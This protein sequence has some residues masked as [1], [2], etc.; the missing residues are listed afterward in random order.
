MWDEIRED[1]VDSFRQDPRVADRWS[2]TEEAVRAGRL[3]P[4]TAACR[5]LRAHAEGPQRDE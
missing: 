1:L 4:T 5:L 3:S 2:G